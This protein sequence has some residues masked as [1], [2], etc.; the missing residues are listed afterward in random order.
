[1]KKLTLALALLLPCTSLTAQ[2]GGNPEEEIRKIME[3]IAAEMSAIDDLLQES[4][5]G[6]SSTSD[7]Q[8]AKNKMEELLKKVDDSG[9]KVVKDIDRLIQELQSMQ[10]QNSQ[11]SQGDDPSSD[12]Q[13]GQSE[14]SQKNERSQRQE[15]QEQSAEQQSQE[16]QGKGQGG[17]QNPKDGQQG[18]G[19]QVPQGETGA[20]EQNKAN[21]G[22]GQ[23]PDYILQH[24]RGSLPEVPEKYKRYLEAL[25]KEGSKKR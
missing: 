2:F 14:G 10:N 7:M 9:T 20:A 17:Q 21:G 12:Q 16:Q 11:S 18:K 1:M 15:N 4:S 13:K 3:E 6:N 8:G 24:G 19:Q 22:W 5:R 25:N 23:L